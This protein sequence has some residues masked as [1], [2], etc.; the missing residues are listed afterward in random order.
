MSLPTTPRIPLNPP[1]RDFFQKPRAQAES[2]ESTDRDTGLNEACQASLAISNTK[3][4]AEENDALLRAS[5]LHHVD[6]FKT[7]TVDQQDVLGMANANILILIKYSEFSSTRSCRFSCFLPARIRLTLEQL[8]STGSESLTGLLADEK[9]Q[10]RAKKAAAPLEPGV[11]HV[12][13]LSPS[14]DEEDFTI[15]LQRLSVTDGIKLWY[16]SM[17]FGVSPLAVAGHDDVCTCVLEIGKPYSLPKRPKKDGETKAE[18]VG[19]NNEVC[20]FDAK[21]WPV[22]E[23]YNIDD[24]CQTRWAACTQRLFRSLAKPAGQKDLLIDSAPRM[25]T[26]VGLFS[27]LEMTNYDLLVSTGSRPRTRLR[28]SID[29]FDSVTKSPPGSMPT[30]TTYLL[31]FAP[32]RHSVSA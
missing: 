30:S 23:H 28:A 7:Q 10:R 27:K 16:R 11:T 25:W 5:Q 32:R 6:L 31:S 24:F 9:H 2:H 8:Q 19:D 14:T 21:E 13:D 3:K 20:I 22:E 26:L 12:I 29:R 15:A 18:I 4:M 1:L 17:A